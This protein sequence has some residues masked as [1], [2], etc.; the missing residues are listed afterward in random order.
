MSN[1]TQD[2]DSISRDDVVWCYRNLLGR[3]PESDTVIDW[4]C[5][6]KSF[7]DLVEQ[8]VKS[9]E[10]RVNIGAADASPQAASLLRT[11][12]S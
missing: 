1:P 10:F 11:R 12:I 5:S 2:P 9:A 8:F 7:R 4:H 6:N 3:E